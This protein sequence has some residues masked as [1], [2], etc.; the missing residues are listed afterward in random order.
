MKKPYLL[1]LTL[2]FCFL[3]SGSLFA[4][5][6]KQVQDLPIFVDFELF[7]GVNLHEV[8]P[9]WNQ[10]KGLPP[11][12]ATISNSAWFRADELHGSAAAAVIYSYHGIKDEWIISPQFLATETSRLSFMAALTRFWDDPVQGNL[13]HNDSVSVMVATEGYAFTETVHSFKFAN[14]PDW[15]GAFYDIDL[16]A[17]AGQTIRVA[18]YATNGQEPNSLAAFHID[19]IVIKDAV[20][21]DAMAFNLVHPATNM[22]FDEETPVV[23]R[24]KNDG[25]EPV[26]SVPVRVRVRG[27]ALHNLY[28]AYQGVIAPGEYVDFEVGAIQNPP[29][30][31]YHFEI[32]TELPGDGFAENNVVS[33]I[34][35]YNDEP[36]QLP[37]PKMTFV[38]FYT[39]NLGDIYPGWYEARGKDWPRVA[40]N[41]DWQGANYDGSRTA[42]VYFSGLG[43]EDWLV[44][45]KFTATDELVVELRAAVEYDW[46]TDQ[47]GSDD[48]LSI[49][50]SADCGE[51][52]HEA[53]ALTN[54][55]GLTESLQ[56]YTFAI[57]G[58][59]GQDIILAFYAT[60]GNINDP[61]SYLMHITDISIKSLYAL[62]AGITQLL[63]P[64]NSCSFTNAEEVIVRIE[65]FG[66]QT[67]SNFD[68]AY[69]LND[70]DPVI[71]T[72]S[73]SLDYGES[74]DYVFQQLADLS[75]DTQHSISVYTM[76]ENDGNPENDG[77]YDIQLR[78]SSFDLATEG[79]YF[80]SF[81]ED[82][83]FAD[84]HVEDGNNDGITWGLV[85]DGQH[86]N[87]G[88]YSFAYF[89]NQSSVPSNDWLFS[90][91]FNLEAGQTYY[92]SFYY[93]NR[94]TNWP[95]SL[96]LNLGTAQTGSAMDQLLIDLGQISNPPYMKAETTFT[97]AE[98]GEY[99]FGWHAYGPADQFGMHIDDVTIYQ[100]FEYDL[101]LTN[102]INPR[103]K[104]ENCMLQPANQIE[105]ELTNF[106]EQ[107]VVGFTVGLLVGDGE[108]ETFG[109]D[110]GIG[111][112]ESLWVTLQN[113]FTIPS[114]EQIDLIIWTDHAQDIN[115]ANDTL[116][117]PGYLMAQ[118][119]TSFEAHENV[120]DWDV[121]NLAGVN[122]WHHLNNPSVARTGDYVYAIRTDG[123]GGNTTNDDWL[124]SECFYLEAGTCYEI[125]F[126]YRSHFSTENLAVYL[127]DAQTH[128]AMS[129]QLINLPSFN[130]NNYLHTSAQ[131]TV[132]ESGVYHFGWHT[133]GGTSGRY[134]IYIDD[135]AVVEDLA[136]QP[137]ADPSYII[138]DREVAFFANAENASSILWEFGDDST[139][140]EENPFH[141]YDA[142]GTYNVTLTIGS[143]CVNASYEMEVELVLPLYDVMFN[144]TD[145]QGNTI[146]DAVIVVGDQQNA[147]GDY[148]FELYQG[149]YDFVVE[150]T[151][152]ETVAGNFTVIDNDIQVDVQ[153]SFTGVGY[154]VSFDVL[155][156]EGEVIEDAV[157]VFNGT[158]GAPGAYFIENV[159]PGV[160]EYSIHKHCY[161][162]ALGEIEVIDA[163]VQVEES[164]LGRPGDANGDGVVNVLDVIAIVAYF[165]DT[166]PEP[167]C[168]DNADVNQDG[169][170]NVLDVI[171]TVT[172]FARN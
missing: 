150:R 157:I 131:F 11:T 40:M 19:D 123:A 15:Q 56:D 107:D 137:V 28:N 132:D 6:D 34:I 156:S 115:T 140:E 102:Y 98:S 71:E 63:A 99:Y 159:L 76:L 85:Q 130:T 125:S 22:C 139:S 16:G 17:F 49:M 68:V 92:I 100:V 170:I 30:G 110:L 146:P 4:N 151:D 112:G 133:D 60:T 89:S 163:H 121:E 41:T 145:Q 90:P 83:D 81:E 152:Y 84:W 95:E 124:F 64:G 75:G 65:N 109:F 114:D 155:D 158:E 164:L 20:A 147:A 104:D 13:S 29:F 96:K 48:K 47:M 162:T 35:R 82:E 59:G 144:I 165:I 72:V 171:A 129:E 43:T 119:F 70:Q 18:F 101:A 26:S 31:E 169:V 39:N 120:D 58:Y 62:D 142:P 79:V 117:I 122:E 161:I 44:G 53:A 77:L 51:T 93:K 80:M 74:I 55:S 3:S 57:E 154:T 67:I 46:N 45:P 33:N 149:G 42:N 27:A 21:K 166:E 73:E 116:Y 54:Q 37:L 113:G 160:Y 135:V 97:V 136:N 138:L 126:Y 88:E 167:F 24:I 168:F 1:I 7:N 172:I 94:A 23:V 106:G 86:A 127:G 143:G 9:G 32:E 87:S 105:V 2:A 141:T 128:T 66:T 103:E 12:P 10:G 50:V 134:F 61:Q 36:R 108:P 69:Q 148:H 5:I 78:L 38:G 14:Q 25:L 8:Y 111:S 118:F 52:W 153:M 91:C